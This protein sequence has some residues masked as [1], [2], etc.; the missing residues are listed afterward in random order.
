MFKT[1]QTFTVIGPFPQTPFLTVENNEDLKYKTQPHVSICSLMQKPSAV[2]NRGT[3]VVE[4]S[5]NDC[6]SMGPWLNPPLNSQP[7]PALPALNATLDQHLGLYWETACEHVCI[8]MY[9][10]TFFPALLS[11]CMC[12]GLC[13][14]CL[15]RC[16]E[17][18]SFS[19]DFCLCL[20]AY[21]YLCDIS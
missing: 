2:V 11:M 14:T 13:I 21:L 16:E 20:F 5:C 18:A 6:G 7:K 19:F 12:R 10:A 3:W 8:F 15:G 9:A 17:I 4:N 1:F